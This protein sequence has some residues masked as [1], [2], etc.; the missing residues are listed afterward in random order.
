MPDGRVLTRDDL[1][2]SFPDNPVVVGHISMHGGVLNSA[3]LERFG[4]MADTR[5]P[6]GGIIVRKPG[7]NEPWGLIM[8]T[9]YLPVFAGLPAPALEEASDAS[10]EAQLMYAEAGITLAQDGATRAADLELL[11]RAAA[12]GANIIDVVAYPYMS[13]LDAI[14]AANPIQTWGEYRDRLKIGGVKVT[15]DGSARGRTAY[16]S[17]PYLAGGPGIEK[18]WYGEPTMAQP[19]LD[20]LVARAY[21]MQVPLLVDANGDAAIDMLLEACDKART[22]D[23]TQPWNVTVVH[24]QFLRRDQILKFV[25]YGIRPSFDTL[26]TYYFASTYEQDRGAEQAAYISPMRD[27]IDAG[28]RPTNHTDFYAAPLDQ[29]FAL[30]SAVNRMSLK[31]VVVDPTQTVTPLEALKSQTLWA[32]EQYGEAGR[33]GSLEV[34]K[35]A[36]LV[37]LDANPLTVDPMS[38]KD[39]RVLETIKEGKTIYRRGAQ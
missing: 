23:F 21:A 12:E 22:G 4:I 5:T 17:T 38:I 18:N 28:L 20:A 34:G 19:E 30:W 24:A 32:A 35:I 15:A 3:A 14:V 39:I 1:D 25:E 8:E 26:D 36:D 37:I 13:D 33:R 11:Q 2:A 29:L 27:A 10:R 9:A 7:S 31:G 6:P 16:F